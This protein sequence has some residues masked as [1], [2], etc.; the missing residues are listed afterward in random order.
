MLAVMAGVPWDLGQLPRQMHLNPV[1]DIFGSP[2]GPRRQRVRKPKDQLDTIAERS[3]SVSIVQESKSQE[4]VERPL[5]SEDVAVEDN[6][7]PKKVQ[8]DQVSALTK[9]LSALRR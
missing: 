9:M 5:D 6:V 4:E 8:K 2:P 3:R 7:L 1:S